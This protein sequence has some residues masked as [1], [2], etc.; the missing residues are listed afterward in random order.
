MSMLPSC[1]E[2]ERHR[3]VRSRHV[4]VGKRLGIRHHALQRVMEHIHDAVEAK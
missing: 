1:F 4:C 2:L 3:E